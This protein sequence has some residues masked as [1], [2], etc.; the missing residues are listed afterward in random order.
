MMAELFEHGY[1]VV[2]GVDENKIERLVGR[3]VSQKPVSVG[4]DQL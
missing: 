2:I 3:N 1:A 4:L